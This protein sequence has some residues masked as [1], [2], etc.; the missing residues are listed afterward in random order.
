MT[1]YFL[2]LFPGIIEAYLEESMMKRAREEGRFQTQI[3][4]IRAFSKDKHHRTDDYPY[5]GG[6]GMVMT[7]QPVADAIKSIPNWEDCTVI[8]LSPAGIRFDQ[9]ESE[10]LYQ[11]NKDI[12]FICG[13]YEGIDQRVIDSYATKCYSAGDYVLTG[14]ELPALIIADAVSRHIPGVLGNHDSLSEETFSEGLLE[15]PQYTR[16]PVFEGQEVPAVLLSGHHKNIR[17]W[18]LEQAEIQ[19]KKARPDLY[20]EYLKNKK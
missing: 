5:G 19:T 10:K 13:H 11:E 17:S 4:D 9:Q 14:G 2:T 20:K 3:L 12:I 15:Y 7:P 18:R 8:H 16:P 6:A 1:Y